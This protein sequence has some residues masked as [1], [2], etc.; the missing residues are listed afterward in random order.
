MTNTAWQ[1]EWQEYT[2]WHQEW[3]EWCDV[4]Q[5]ATCGDL[6]CDTRSNMRDVMINK[7]QAVMTWELLYDTRT[8]RKSGDT[9]SDRVVINKLW[10]HARCYATTNDRSNVVTNQVWWREVLWH[11]DWQAKSCDKHA[12]MMTREMSWHKNWQE[13]SDDKQGVVTWVVWR[14]WGR[15]WGVPLSLTHPHLASGRCNSLSC[16]FWT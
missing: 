12:A 16:I 10:W 6:L 14:E 5:G 1:W 13:W 8:D 15:H 11:N 9:R 3:R 4:S 2:A 7:E